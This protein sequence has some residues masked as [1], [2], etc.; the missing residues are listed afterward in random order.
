MFYWLSSI[1]GKHDISLWKRFMSS[2][3]RGDGSILL[4]LRWTNPY[5]RHRKS[6]SFI[7]RD[8]RFIQIIYKSDSKFYKQSHLHNKYLLL[9]G[10]VHASFHERVEAEVQ[11]N[12]CKVFDLIPQYSLSSMMRLT[13]E[14]N[15]QQNLT[16]WLVDASTT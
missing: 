8:R 15:L 10:I 3:S 7:T 11:R 9:D 1:P 13:R 6:T 4:N 2:I 14:I 16:K 12:W 5:K